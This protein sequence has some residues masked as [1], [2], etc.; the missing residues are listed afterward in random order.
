MKRYLILI[1]IALLLI[2][3][4]LLLNH[5]IK[6][7]QKQ[8]AEEKGTYFDEYRG[9][10]E[11]RGRAIERWRESGSSRKP[12]K[13]IIRAIEDAPAD[14]DYMPDDTEEEYGL[15]DAFRGLSEEEAEKILDEV[16]SGEDE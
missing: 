3:R 2:G 11:A 16:L 7:H 15:E 8:L 5:L 13:T 1:P 9:P 12:R 10:D 4:K 6:K 14:P